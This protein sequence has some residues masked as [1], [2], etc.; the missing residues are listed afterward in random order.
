MTLASIEDLKE[1]LEW[2]LTDDEER[3]AVAALSDLSVDAISHGRAWTASTVP[4]IVKRI[5][6]AAA[7]RYLRNLEG[8]STSRAGDETLSYP[9]IYAE[10]AEE[11]GSARF[12]TAEVQKIIQAAMG[13][14]AGIG[15]IQIVVNS[16]AS[17]GRGERV[18]VSSGG[19]P[20]PFFHQDDPR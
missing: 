3:V 16:A 12:S 7:T 6:L 1:R 5:I 20:F 2:E 17:A 9:E 18:P 19:K 4:Q 14:N 13:A 8:A 15:S 11:A 10:A